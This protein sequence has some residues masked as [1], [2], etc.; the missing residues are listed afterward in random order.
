MVW[1]HPV[2][3]FALAAVAAPILI[4]ILVQRRAEVVPFPTLRFLRPTAL[5]SIR[6]HLLDD[7]L[8]LTVRIAIVTAAV[9][10]VAGPLL[11]T[12]ARG[13]AWNRRIVRA[14]VMSGVPAVSEG[15]SRDGERAFQTREFRG[16]S[17]ADGIRR[18]RAWLDA[19]PPARRE[20]VVAA[21]LPIGSLSA[22]EIADVPPSVGIRFERVGTVPGERTVSY[23]SVRSVDGS[24]ERE[25][26]LA[27]AQTS[28]RDRSTSG[29]KA[30]ADRGFP[31]DVLAPS[32]ARPFLDAAIAAV[33]G[34]R[35]WSP[36]EAHGARLILVSTENAAAE[37]GADNGDV[38]PWIADAIVRLTRDDDLQRASTRLAGALEEPRFSQAPWFT[39]A[40]SRDNHLLIAAAASAGRLVVVAGVPPSDIV[41]PILV[42]GIVNAIAVVPDIVPLEIVPIPDAQLTAWSRPAARPPPPRIDRIESDDRRWL[43]IAALGL[44]VVETWM[45]RSARR[46]AAPVHAG[47][48]ARVA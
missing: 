14:T 27:G 29:P 5:A 30:D 38:Q 19:A 39:V 2:I 9:T 32:S 37:V 23:G 13:D 21:P 16:P 44:L 25:V 15:A 18:A 40:R 35:V 28:V 3:L 17:L 6:R 36:P 46:D 43:W 4:H 22:A 12:R 10:A 45:R 31:L 7:P 33:L 1:L 41:L 47:E 11:V 20:M 24:I 26:T 42:R 34:E 48:S 8:L